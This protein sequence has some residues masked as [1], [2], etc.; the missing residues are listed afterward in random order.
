[1]KELSGYKLIAVVQRPKLDSY[2]TY[3]V[4]AD[5]KDVTDAR[6]KELQFGFYQGIDDNHNANKP[7]YVTTKIRNLFYL[8]GGDNGVRIDYYL[9]PISAMWDFTAA[10][11][12]Y[13]EDNT[14]DSFFLFHEELLAKKNDNHTYHNQLL[15]DEFY[16]KLTS[17][18]W[19]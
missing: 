2:F 15:T 9:V 19:L 14:E 7:S 3:W 8:S 4:E 1:M 12:W 5:F 10:I 17:N 13:I 18:G 16:N 11:K 6:L